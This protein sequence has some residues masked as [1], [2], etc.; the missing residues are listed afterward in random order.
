MCASLDCFL[1][2]PGYE[3]EGWVAAYHYREIPWT[4]LV[5]MARP[6]PNPAAADAAFRT[7][8]TRDAIT[9]SVECPITLGF[10][11]D[12]YV[13]TCAHRQCAA[14]QRVSSIRAHDGS[15]HLR[16]PARTFARMRGRHRAGCQDERLDGHES[17]RAG[18]GGSFEQ[19]EKYLSRKQASVS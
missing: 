13:F 10:L 19:L 6:Q 7:R 2:G 4:E 5:E 12:D 1:R 14:P 18:F 8:E 16:R 15:D 17:M 9:A 11:I 3:Q